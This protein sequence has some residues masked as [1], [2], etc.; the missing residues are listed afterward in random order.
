[1]D[2][3]ARLMRA[4]GAKV[5]PARDPAFTLAVIRAAEQRRFKAAT[6]LAL[7][8]TA[9]MAAAAAALVLPLLA[10]VPGNMAALEQGVVMAGAM[11]TL[12]GVARLMSQ[13][14]TVGAR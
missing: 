12:V 2:S 4:L 8:R 1:M 5:A 10:W 6:L 11:L 13:R 9:G 14:L 3:E 7:L